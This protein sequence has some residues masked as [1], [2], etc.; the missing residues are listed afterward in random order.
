MPM[1]GLLVD[2]VGSFNTMQLN[3]KPYRAKNINPTYMM[4]QVSRNVYG[5]YTDGLTV[6]GMVLR[7]DF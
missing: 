7:P 1:E 3:E 4:K 5:H 6:E 2:L